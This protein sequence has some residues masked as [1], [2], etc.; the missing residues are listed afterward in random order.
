[1]GAGTYECL[2]I[3]WMTRIPTDEASTVVAT[4]IWYAPEIGYFVKQLRSGIVTELEQH[5]RG[6]ET[7]G[8]G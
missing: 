5:S 3:W 8:G 6:A 4:L 2:R 1:M 7:P